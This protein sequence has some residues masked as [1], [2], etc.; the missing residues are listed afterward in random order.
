MAAAVSLGDPP[1]T[2]VPQTL[3]IKTEKDITG[4][5]YSY[6]VVESGKRFIV[7]RPVS[8]ERQPP[9]TILLNWTSMLSK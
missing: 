1:T 2:N 4:W 3:L 6:D 9:M 5:R 7:S 8:N